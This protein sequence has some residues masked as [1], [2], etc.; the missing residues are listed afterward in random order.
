MAE[1]LNTYRRTLAIAQEGE[2][3]ARGI[4]VGR[5]ARDVAALIGMVEEARKERDKYRQDWSY[6]QGREASANAHLWRLEVERDALK[7]ELA[8]HHER[9]KDCVGWGE[10]S[11]CGIHKGGP[12]LKDQP[13]TAVTCGAC[14]M[15]FPNMET[16]ANHVCKRLQPNPINEG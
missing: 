12:W 3:I 2:P 9:A 7:A 14:G 11:K 4:W 13:I 15:G 16:A 10:A 5:Y 6:S 1:D 8:D